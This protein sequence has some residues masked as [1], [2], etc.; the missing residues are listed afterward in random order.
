M[1]ATV[2]EWDDVLQVVWASVAAGVGVTLAFSLAIV[3]ATREVDLRRDGHGAAASLYAVLMV[4][5]L[6]VTGAAIAFGIIVMT[7]KD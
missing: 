4:L 1:F 7:S 3:G 2:V 5:G 6:V